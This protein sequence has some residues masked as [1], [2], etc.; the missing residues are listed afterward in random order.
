MQIVNSIYKIHEGGACKAG[1]F[2]STIAGNRRFSGAS[3]RITASTESN[4]VVREQFEA[5]A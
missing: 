2:S 3:S 4:V 5:A 1:F